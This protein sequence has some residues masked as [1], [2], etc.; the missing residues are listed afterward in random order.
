MARKIRYGLLAL[1]I[2]AP[3]VAFGWTLSSS[4]AG[5]AAFLNEDTGN[6]APTKTY[7]PFFATLGADF[8]PVGVTGDFSSR[9]ETSGFRPGPT[10]EAGVAA[11]YALIGGERWEVFGAAGFGFSRSP[12]GEAWLLGPPPTYDWTPI[13]A[14]GVR[15]GPF[16]KVDVAGGVDYRER[17]Q[18][19]YSMLEMSHGAVESPTITAAVAADYRAFERVA[20]GLEYRRSWYGPYEYYPGVPGEVR[21]T[22]GFTT[23]VESYVLFVLSVDFVRAP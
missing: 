22:E 7:Y 11:D 20:L 4:L 10:V 5:G 3:C 1:L 6:P 13:A 21:R 17:Q 12:V 8:G 14:A 16:Y 9:H 2:V 15:A 19:L 18:I 23:A